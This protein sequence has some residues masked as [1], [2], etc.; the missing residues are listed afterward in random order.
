M[1]LEHFVIFTYGTNNDDHFAQYIAVSFPSVVCLGEVDCVCICNGR[2]IRK[3]SIEDA[4]HPFFGCTT[5]VIV[6]NF[7]SLKRWPWPRVLRVT[8][9]HG[10][11][12]WPFDDGHHKKNGLPDPVSIWMINFKLTFYAPCRAHNKESNDFYRQGT[13]FLSTCTKVYSSYKTYIR[14]YNENL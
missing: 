11:L 12:A 4:A 2:F 3:G 8:F 14:K 9:G 1:N 6:F 10:H 7:S 5:E 13:I